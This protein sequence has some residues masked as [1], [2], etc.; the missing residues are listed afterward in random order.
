MK[1]NN[2]LLL[3][4]SRALAEQSPYFE[5]FKKRN[6]E[7]L[8]CYEPYDELVLMHL[9]RFKSYDIISV[10]KEMHQNTEPSESDKTGEKLGI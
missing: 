5:S 8:F 3:N 6:L 2:Y 1:V 10:E 9:R 7:V 4:C